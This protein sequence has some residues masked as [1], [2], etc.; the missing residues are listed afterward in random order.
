MRGGE[1]MQRKFEEFVVEQ[2]N[3]DIM[4]FEDF[5]SISENYIADPDLDLFC[6]ELGKLRIHAWPV[7]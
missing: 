1:N 3:S 2:P 5:R 6:D 7:I 4:E